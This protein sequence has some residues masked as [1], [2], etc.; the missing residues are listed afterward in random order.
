MPGDKKRSPF[1]AEEDWWAVWF[2]L[3]IV[4]VATVL[5]AL[6]LSGALHE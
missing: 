5:G 1:L 4:V 3:T 6:S 2:G